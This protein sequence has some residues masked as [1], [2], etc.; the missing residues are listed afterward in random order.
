[1]EEIWKEVNGYEGFYEVSSLGRVRSIS[2]RIADKRCP[3]GKYHKG[4]ILKPGYTVNGY[5]QVLL[6]ANGKYKSCRVHRLVAE[7]FIPNTENKSEV[8]HKNGVK[9]DNRLENLEWNTR[10]E[11]AAHMYRKLKIPPNKGMEGKVSRF[12]KL[13]NEQVEAIKAD[14]RGFDTIAQEYGIS[15]QTVSNIKLERIYVNR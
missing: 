14:I 4:R 12:R 5:L 2:C 6:R 11:N 9:T 7:A 8:N 1:M 3:N 10:S 13:T 15:K